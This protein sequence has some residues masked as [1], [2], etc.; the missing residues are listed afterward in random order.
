MNLL[1]KRFNINI[2]K[3][4]REKYGNQDCLLHVTLLK[5][6]NKKKI[7]LLTVEAVGFTP[8]YFHRPQCSL[9]N[10]VGG[11]AEVYI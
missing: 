1:I 8:F 7:N 9:C 4:K 10:I 6:N 2:Q 3:E 11:G 5:D